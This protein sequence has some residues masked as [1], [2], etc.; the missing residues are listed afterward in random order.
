M[1]LRD[2]PVVSA[3]VSAVVEAGPDD[4]VF[5]SLLLL[6]LPVIVVIAVLGRWWLTEALALAYLVAFV[7]YVAYRG[8]RE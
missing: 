3:V 6:G 5:D 4:P 2:I 1:T 8:I 7:G